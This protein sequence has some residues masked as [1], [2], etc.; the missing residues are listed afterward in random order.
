MY[1]V[2]QILSTLHFN[3]SEMNPGVRHYLHYLDDNLDRYSLSTGVVDVETPVGGWH[4]YE[5]GIK[6]VGSAS[7]RAAKQAERLKQLDVRA[8]HQ[9]GGLPPFSEDSSRMLLA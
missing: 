3:R 8:A 7:S 6:S 2:H 1:Q 5:E 9:N 4:A